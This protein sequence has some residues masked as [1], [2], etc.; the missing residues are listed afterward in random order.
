MAGT[1]FLWHQAVSKKGNTQDIGVDSIK[2][3]DKRGQMLAFA[4]S[5]LYARFLIQHFI[6]YDRFFF[7]L[8]F[9]FQSD[10]GKRHDC[11]LLEV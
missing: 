8:D 4:L 11:N 6:E 10:V 7:A 1:S 5:Y 2:I 3:K 9:Q